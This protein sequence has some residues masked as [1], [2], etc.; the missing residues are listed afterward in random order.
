MEY[1][2]LASL[3]NNNAITTGLYDIPKFYQ[4][5]SAYYWS[6]KPNYFWGSIGLSR[7]R[8][9]IEYEAPNMGNKVFASSLNDTPIATVYDVFLVFSSG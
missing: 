2:V 1:S 6:C 7:G 3:L 5:N 4:T 8:I 9:S